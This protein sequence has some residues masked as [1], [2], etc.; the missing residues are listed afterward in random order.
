[1]S[2]EKT[3]DQLQKQ[4]EMANKE[5]ASLSYSISH[6]LRSPLQVID[7][8]SEA[9]AEEYQDKLDERGLDYLKRIRSA[10]AR[11][12]QL[13]DKLLELA[14]VTRTEIRHERVNL[15]EIAKSIAD[16]LQRSEPARGVRFS[17][18]PGLTTDGDPHLL[19]VALEHLLRNSWKFTSKH[20][21]AV[22]EV[23]TEEKDGRRVFFVRDDGAGFDPTYVGKMFGAFQR[24]HSV[25]QFEGAGIGLAMVQRIVR[26]HGGEVWAVGAVER[27][28]TIYIDW[29]E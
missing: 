11:M 16:E 19:R 9:L 26:R 18:Q 14:R 29:Y 22:I 10:A 17:I 21:S 15:S 8:F 20:S 4:L 7:G 23:G 5:L 12:G 13:I 1:V 24:L 25:S 3:F 27:G 6:D 2:A 28:A